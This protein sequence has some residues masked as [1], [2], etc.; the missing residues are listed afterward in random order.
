M[1]RQ[2]FSVVLVS[3]LL[4]GATAGIG[5]ALD[6]SPFVEGEPV[7]DIYAPEPTLDSGETTDLTV[8]IANSG[9]LE[10]GTIEQRE[11]VTTARSV[12]VAF[13]D[14]NIPFTVET[15]QQS[16]GLIADGSVTEIPVTVTVPDDVTPGK[17]S[18][19]VV[20]EYT[21]TFRFK[22]DSNFIQ[23]RSRTARESVDVRIDDEPQ[24]ELQ[25]LESNVQ[26]GGS[27][28]IITEITN[29]GS[30]TA[31]DLVVELTSASGDVT[32][33][34]TEK[35]TAR[36]DQLSPGEKTTLTYEANVRS[37][38]SLRNFALRGSVQ[39][40][41]PDGI[42]ETQDELSVGLQPQPEQEFSLSVN[43][44][45]L[46]VGET[47]RIKGTIQNDGPADVS[48]MVLV[49]G[50]TQ[51][52]SRSTTY[53]VGD[54]TADKSKAFQFRGTVPS[55]ADAVPQQIDVRAQYRTPVDN[56]RVF[57]DSIHVSVEDR[58][59]VVTVAAID[60]EFTAGEE[61][62]LDLEITNQRDIEL[63]DV[64]LGLVV[65]EPLQSE[66]RTSVIPSLQPEESAQIAF[67]LEIN[68]DA[69]ESQFPATVQVTYL[70]Q[71]GER[72]TARASTIAIRVTE[73]DRGEFPTE[74]A[75]FGILVAIV[76]VG[77]W[78]FYRR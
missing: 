12:T 28:T 36:I 2:I 57:E 47:G 22:P 54:L 27:G 21:H 50:E 30:E 70:D 65:E 9:E 35:N 58:R 8:Q 56:E 44:S 33:G 48:D 31:R 78:L 46:R 38:A 45:T 18:I 72:N 29:V 1:N 67:D 3:I 43:E 63:R 49:L 64:Q 4:I 7:L 37:D 74:F 13:K 52:E 17:Y 73:S 26:L 55:E 71:D 32:L 25:T 68:S 16:L 75:I 24:F 53:S 62:V 60:P 51:F 11:T 39:F 20:I 34:E 6:E 14:G 41:D 23:E 61:G 5:V 76:L 59:D 10:S 77:A 19:D 69:P 40:T 15:R 42:R 66:F